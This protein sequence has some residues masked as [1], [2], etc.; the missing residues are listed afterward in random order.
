MPFVTRSFAAGEVIAQKYLLLHLLGRG[1]SGE[2]FRARNIL[3][4]NVLALKLFIEDPGR[5]SGLV[6]RFLREGRAI[7]RISH[8]NIVSVFDAGYADGIPF[9]AMEYLSGEPLAQ[10]LARTPKLPLACVAAILLK[11]LEAL[12]AAHKADIVHRDLKPANVF[13]QVCDGGPPRVKLLD[14]GVAKIHEEGELSIKTESGMILG[15]P[16][17]LSPEQITADGDVDGRSDLF[18]AGSLMFELLTGKRPFHGPSFVTTTYRIVHEPAPS[19][20]EAGGP[21]DPAVAQ[22]VAKALSKEVEG[23]FCS[24]AEFAYHLE[25][26]SPDASARAA[27]LLDLGVRPPSASVHWDTPSPAPPVR[28][29][30]GLPATRGDPSGPLLVEPRMLTPSSSARAE[31]TRRKLSRTWSDLPIIG[32]GRGKGKRRSEQGAD[33]RVRGTVLVAMDRAITTRYGGDVR[34]EILGA[35]PREARDI[36]HGGA[37]SAEAWH[38]IVQMAAYLDSCN[39][40]A[41]HDDGGRWRALGSAGV[42]TDLLTL[43]RS[44]RNQTD[45]YVALRE[46][47]PIIAGLFDFG[48]WS[49]QGDS[50][51][52]RLIADGLARTPASLHD[53]LAGV[54]EQSARSTGRPYRVSIHRE[55][56]HA[57]EDS[58]IQFTAALVGYVD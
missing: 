21:E 51:S 6:Q 58:A 30:A 40:V 19:L 1:A 13:L 42:E 2:V 24:A 38:S 4:G 55:A 57:A 27:A 39:Q 50:Q 35:L 36:F 34:E 22:V 16:D 47:L 54:I 28:G 15:T 17:Y 53:W 23:R 44:A 45:G 20:A 12:E 18:A 41:V 49:L 9:I 48:R 52:V 8:P 29:E 46:A 26:I 33:G 11:I 14:F 3:A 10:V 5:D 31:P 37:P 25:K 56:N 7:N 32:K 43:L